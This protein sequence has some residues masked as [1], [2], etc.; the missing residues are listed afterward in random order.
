MMVKARR[1][2]HFEI[3]GGNLALDLANTRERRPTPQPLEHLQRYEDLV[4]WAVQADAVRAEEGATLRTWA[5][6][7]PRAARAALG[8]ALQLREAI[9]TVFS[10]L[11]GGRPLPAGALAR[12]NRALPA[13]LSRLRLAA[14]AKGASWTWTEAPH[15]DRI[16]WPVLRAAAL[17]LTSAEGGRV[18]ECAAR[19]CA[20]L[21][22]DRSHNRTRRW[23]NMTVCGNREKARRFQRRAH[24]RPPRRTP[25]RPPM[26]R[27]PRAPRPRSSG[28]RP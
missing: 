15:L 19:D 16:L 10:A 2:V 21:F 25:Y 22:I 28:G 7:R 9:F 6:R 27:R 3:T 23:C 24:R 8:R 18:R 12:L 4:A 11:A 14:R 20:W 17:L 1:T 26:V 5:A 13:T